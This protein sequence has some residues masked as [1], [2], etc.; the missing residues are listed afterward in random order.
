MISQS[1]FLKQGIM[2]DYLRDKTR[3]YLFYAF[4][5]L[6]GIVKSEVGNEKDY[7][8]ILENRKNYKDILLKN[9]RFTKDDEPFSLAIQYTEALSNGKI[10][11][12][13]KIESVG[14]LNNIYGHLEIQGNEEVVLVN[15]QNNVKIGD[16]ILTIVNEND[17][18]L[19]YNSENGLLNKYN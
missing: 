13:P 15:S 19:I 9:I 6:F 8:E 5:S 17:K 16:E 2:I 10:V 3:E 18:S 7:F 1:Y 4:L 11:F 12:V 14:N